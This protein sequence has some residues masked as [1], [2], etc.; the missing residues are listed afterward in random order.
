MVQEIIKILKKRGHTITFAESCTGGR[1]SSAFTA[2]S[3]VSSILNGAVITYSNGIKSQWLN[4]KESTLIRYGAVSSQCISEMLEGII[5]L[6][7]ADGA[8]A[9]SGIAGPSGGTK[10]K[11]VGTVYIGVKYLD[12]I[13]IKHYLFNG[14]REEIQQ[15][16]TNKAIKLFFKNL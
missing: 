2:I 10:E 3:G 5:K 16:A 6:T 1:V 11:P 13:I 14:S 7:N 15:E 4:V 8:I 12:K 9:I